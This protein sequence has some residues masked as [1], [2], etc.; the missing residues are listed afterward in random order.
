MSRRNSHSL[1]LP[2][3]SGV[4][5]VTARK[6]SGITVVR[7]DPPPPASLCVMAWRAARLVSSVMKTVQR[8]ET[9]EGD[10]CEII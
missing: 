6:S 7:R 9:R 3:C 2:C 1:L 5:I 8:R 4:P 10:S